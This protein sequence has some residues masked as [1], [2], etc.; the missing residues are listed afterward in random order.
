MIEEKWIIRQQDPELVAQI[1]TQHALPESVAR[2]LCNRGLINEEDIQRFLKNDLTENLHDPFLLTDMDRAVTRVEQALEKNEKITV[3]GDYDVD[4]I[5]ST[6]ILYQYLSGRTEAIDYYIPSRLEEGYG[7]N[8]AAVDAIRASGS[9]LLITVDTGTTAVSEIAYAKSIGLDVVVTDH[10]EC[11][12]LLPDCPVVNPKRKDSAYPFPELA[13]VG[14]VLKFISACMKDPLEAFRKYGGITAI[15]TIADIMPLLDENRCIVHY[16]LKQLEQNCPPGIEALLRLSGSTDGTID[17]NV[18]AYQIAPRMNAAG[19]ISD[20]R[21]SVQLLLEK[22]SQKAEDL[23]KI[24]C[25]CNVERKEKEQRVIRDIDLL[26]AGHEPQNKILIYASEYWHNGVIGIA[27][28]RLTERYSRPC[29]LICF[30][31][32]SAK[33]SARSVRGVNLFELIGKSSQFLENFGGHEMAVG[34]TLK[35]ENYERFLQDV[36]E[37]AN[38]SIPDQALIPTCEAEFKVDETAFD[39]S[40]VHTLSV[41]EPYG[42]GNPY[43]TVVAENLKLRSVTGVGNGKHTRLLL[44]KNGRDISAMWFGHAPEELDCSEGD[45][46]DICCTVTEKIFRQKPML[47]VTIKSLRISGDKED[48]AF[49]Q[50]Y[51]SYRDKNEELPQNCK[52]NRSIM[53]SLYRYL[54]GTGFRNGNESTVLQRPETVIRTVNNRYGTALNYCRLMLCLDTMQELGLIR[55]KQDK[56]LLITVFSTEKKVDL[57]SA[58]DW[59]RISFSEKG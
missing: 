20:C 42:N 31:E 2:L 58:H 22:D 59:E 56:T 55:Y 9:S 39:L 4:G 33:G 12:E 52:I 51:H 49:R 3:Y 53:V 11:M 7:L 23:A 30:E 19:R 6:V 37:N 28:S 36:R 29:I 47:N 50:A 34:L 14:V 46:I 32:D 27:A 17:T 10:H 54:T 44:E 45:L 43:P 18:V 13:G 21:I 40:F 57:C 35:K 15:G 38:R 41:M 16:G 5:T 48:P 1:Q 8:C 26:L 25:D 24:L